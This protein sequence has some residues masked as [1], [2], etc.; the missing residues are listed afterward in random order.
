MRTPATVI[1]FLLLSVSLAFAQSEPVPRYAV[2]GLVIVPHT[3]NYDPMEVRL[4]SDT[5]IPM[6][7]TLV[8]PQERFVFYNLPAGRYYVLINVPGFKA[9]RHRVDVAGFATGADGTI[10]LEPS[11]EKSAPKPL[12]LT[13]DAGLVDVTEM[14]RTTAKTSKFLEEAEKKLKREQSSKPGASSSRLCARR[15]IPTTDTGCWPLH[16]AKAGVTRTPRKSTEP[17]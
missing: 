14:K 12:Y 9:V 4:I 16:I 17:R 1:L 10:V 7:R 11:E 13:G 3:P 2:G 5:E 8:R 6:G 15:R